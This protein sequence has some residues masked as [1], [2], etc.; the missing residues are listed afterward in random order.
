[1]NWVE[2]PNS[3]NI[4]RYK[5]DER[6]HVLTVEFKNGGLTITT[7]CHRGRLTK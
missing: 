2:T 3:S 4:A 7:M 6:T 1:M 5:Y